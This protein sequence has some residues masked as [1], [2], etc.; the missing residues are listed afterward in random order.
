MS[1]F[2]A[3][4]ECLLTLAGFSTMGDFPLFNFHIK[5]M[6]SGLLCSL[7]F[8]DNTFLQAFPVLRWCWQVPCAPVRWICSRH[9]L[10]I[11][12]VV[13]TSVADVYCLCCGGTLYWFSCSSSRSR[14][15]SIGHLRQYCP[16]DVVSR[17]STDCQGAGAVSPAAALLLGPVL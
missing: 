14:S 8:F 5:I 7:C 9:L 17:L 16:L 11:C 12:L 13:S 1:T 6:N 10:K 2:F 15:S 4:V 3:W